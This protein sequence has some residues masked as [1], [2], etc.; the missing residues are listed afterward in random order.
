MPSCSRQAETP[1]LSITF[2][3]KFRRAVLGLIEL[4]PLSKK[5]S[6]LFHSKAPSSFH[7]IIE[8]LFLLLNFPMNHPSERGFC[9]PVVF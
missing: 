3:S 8:L 1:V 6:A 2:T 5:L 9:K 4:Y 7:D